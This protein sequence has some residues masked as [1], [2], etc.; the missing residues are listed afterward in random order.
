[1]GVLFRAVSVTSSRGLG[2]LDVSDVQGIIN[3]KDIWSSWRVQKIGD[4]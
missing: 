1:M 3:F 2:R 4:Q